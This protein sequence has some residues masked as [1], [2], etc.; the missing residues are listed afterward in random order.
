MAIY[1]RFYL[2]RKAVFLDEAG[3]RIGVS[4]VT[5]E[6]FGFEML[7]DGG[8]IRAELQTKFSE[9]N[10]VV[11]KFVQFSVLTS[12]QSVVESQGGKR[13]TRAERAR[14]CVPELKRPLQHADHFARP[15]WPAIERRPAFGPEAIKF[16]FD[17]GGRATQEFEFFAHGSMGQVSLFSKVRP[18][19]AYPDVWRK[20]SRDPLASPA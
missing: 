7:E 16:F 10:C 5:L 15:L 13:P 11:A 14:G 8:L 17:S 19:Y 3:D 18:V 20:G 1:I 6:S 12:G 4:F 9:F 2:N